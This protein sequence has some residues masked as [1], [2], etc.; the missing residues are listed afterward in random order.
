MPAPGGTGRMPVASL[1][2]DPNRF[3]YKL[4]TNTE[5]VSD[6]F[7]DVKFN[8]EFAGQIHVWNDPEDGNNYV[9]NGHH[10]HELAER[11][12]YDGDMSVYHIDEPTAELARAKGAMINM[13][14]GN[15]TAVDAAKFLRDSGRSLDDLKDAGISLKGGIARDATVLSKLS[16]K[17]FDRTA[18]GLI[19]PSRAVAIAQHL[20]DH[21][22]QERLASTIDK[23][24]NAG[25][26]ALS[27]STVTEMSRQAGLASRS[28]ESQPVLFGGGEE[29]NLFVER[30]QLVSGLRRKMAERLNKFK[31]V[32][33][34]KAANTLAQHN[35][36]DTGA[37][38]SEAQKLAIKLS[39]FNRESGFSGRVSDII[40][41]HAE[42]LA[43]AP[44]S[45]ASVI[46]QLSDAIH[47][48]YDA[49]SENQPRAASPD[50]GEG[51]GSIPG[52]IGQPYKSAAGQ[53]DF[54]SRRRS[55]SRPVISSRSSLA[56]AI[57]ERFRS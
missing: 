56:A 49:L 31:A 8:P 28:T 38:K 54:F 45:R 30:A 39:D 55:G 21:G 16:P 5:G 53:K 51:Q 41:Q 42:M 20:D 32:S 9:I 14:G 50:G 15:G 34:T 18:T 12:G 27:D 19:T 23:R 10:R 1:K 11:S 57:A 46:G 2:R 22:D 7:A 29:K 4:N 52:G 6:Q 43:D 25:G 37:N 3:Q 35:Q 24:E 26:R 13:A 40:N 48:H 33:T 47:G 36:I 17:L 44:N